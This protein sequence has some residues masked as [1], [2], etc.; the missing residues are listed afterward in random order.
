MSIRLAV[1]LSLLAGMVSAEVRSV[2][3]PAACVSADGRVLSHVVV[4]G[5]RCD[6]YFARVSQAGLPAPLSNPRVAPFP[7]TAPAGY[8]N[9]WQDGRINPFRGLPPR[10]LAGS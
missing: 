10:L 7:L 6:A 8:E 3:L 2:I 4:N 1:L 9:V 5:V